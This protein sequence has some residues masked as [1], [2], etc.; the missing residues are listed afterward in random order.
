[1]RDGERYREEEQILWTIVIDDLR[2]T[3]HQ[4]YGNMSDPTYLIDRDGRVAFYNMWTHVPTLYRA[5]RA[6]M[7]QGGSGVALNGIDRGMHFA[8]AMTA[9]WRSIQRGLPQS[10]LDLET[11]APTMGASLWLGYQL[12]PLLAPITQRERPLPIAA[13]ISLAAAGIGLS[14][15]LARRDFQ[16]RPRVNNER[17]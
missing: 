9:G 5:I 6:L 7:R 17:V 1:M 4:V 15:L 2:G 13:K 11:A 10:Y 16:H 8:P 12:R 14:F 3:T